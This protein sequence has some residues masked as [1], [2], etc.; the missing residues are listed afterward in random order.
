MTVLYGLD[1]TKVA[2]VHG[3]VI[4]TCRGEQL[5]IHGIDLF[6]GE[7]GQV[8]TYTD[9]VVYN[10]DSVPQAGIDPKWNLQ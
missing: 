7:V 2:D 10:M 4:V 3:S 1:R 9:G 8:G 5:E 6:Y